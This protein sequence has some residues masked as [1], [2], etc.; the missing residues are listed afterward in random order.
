MDRCETRG[1]CRHDDTPKQS[2]EG[3]AGAIGAEP[4]EPVM[5]AVY[6][7]RGAPEQPAGLSGRHAP[8]LDALVE[9]YRRLAQDVRREEAR[10]LAR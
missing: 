9:Q 7:A 8:T 3:G 2:L 1:A 6:D 5:A 10:A 4:V